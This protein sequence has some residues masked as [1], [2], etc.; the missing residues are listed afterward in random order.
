M[1][2]VKDFTLTCPL[3]ITDYPTVTLAHGGGGKLMHQLIEKM[4]L[5]AFQ[6]PLLDTRH[7]GAVF[8]LGGARLAFTTDSYVVHPL[9]FPGGDIGSLAINGTVNDLSMCGARPMYLSCGLILEEGL[10]METLWAVVQSLKRSA[11]I[12]GV[13]LVTG[14]TKVVDRGKGDGVFINTAG[15]GIVEHGLTI[16]P[17]SVQAG[18][19]ILLSGDI[20][21]HGIAIM[22]M[23]EGLE[24]E[25]AIESD[26][27]PLNTPVQALISG[28]VGVHCMRDLTRGGLGTTL[29]EIAEATGLQITIEE[30]QIPVRDDVGGACE[31][32]GF[33]PLYL[34][35]EGRMIVFVP[36]QESERAL[37]LLRSDKH[38]ADAVRIGRVSADRGG[39][40]KMKS[41]IGTTRII[42][43]LSGEQL[44]RIC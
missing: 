1:S 30:A 22:A 32:L 5:P 34:A 7:D 35:N 18:D 8:Q 37:E 10:P 33:D 15:V 25:S 29:I 19:V 9:F 2:T 40:V 24:F 11:E 28:N 20:G 31:V 26:C 44:P 12:A 6:S 23:R 14:D 39:L 21:R 3:P 17:S 16:A 38:T 4:I 13:Q 36:E 42:D 27:A 41:R 43:M